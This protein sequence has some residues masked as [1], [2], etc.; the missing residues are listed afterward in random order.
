MNTKDMPK[1]SIIVP[2]YNCERYLE[3]CINSLINQTLND[4]EIIIVDDGSTDSSLRIA[5]KYSQLDSRVKT[6]SREHL[7]QGAARNFGMS[8]ACGEYIGFVDSDDWID[9]DYYEKLYTAAKKY[10]SDVAIASNKR[11]GEKR[12][13]TRLNIKSEKFVSDLKGK[14]V[15]SNLAKNPC[16]TNKIYRFAMLKDNNITWPEGMY[17]EDKL[18]TVKALYYANGIV[19]APGVC[20][21]Y[22]RHSDSTVKSNLVGHENDKNIAR[23]QVIEF[24]KEQN[25]KELDKYFY[26]EKRN[27]KLFNI[28]IY[29]VKS[30]ICSEIVY[31]FGIPVWVRKS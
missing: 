1:V 2:V 31:L 17:C 7:L 26:A 23:Y 29:T 22:F 4:I 20:Y 5:E 10:N 18:F 24:L 25:A 15:L 12:T 16:P 6:F 28:P 19:T 8:C 3:R 11:V 27:I 21:Y 30:R 13:K 9:L 14:C